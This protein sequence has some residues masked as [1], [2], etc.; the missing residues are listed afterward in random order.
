MWKKREDAFGKDAM[1]RVIPSDGFPA[2]LTRWAK[3]VPREWIGRRVWCYGAQSYRPSE[4]PPRKPF[5]LLNRWFPCPKAYRWSRVPAS[6]FRITAHRALFMSRV[7]SM[8]RTVLVQGGAGA[9][10]VR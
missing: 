5:F 8:G 6:A 2:L 1:P 3:G 9:G 4:L 10:G 7:R